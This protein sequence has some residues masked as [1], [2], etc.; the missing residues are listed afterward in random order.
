MATAKYDL[1]ELGYPFDTYPRFKVVTDRHALPIEA[2]P[3]NS[4]EVTGT[5][6]QLDALHKE[7][8]PETPPPPPAW[9]FKP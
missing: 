6:E 8:R 7:L 3:P 1:G 5:P 9:M 4:V 2:V